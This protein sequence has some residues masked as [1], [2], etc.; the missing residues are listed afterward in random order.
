M[1]SPY[2]L[3]TFDERLIFSR[4]C[5]LSRINEPVYRIWFAASPTTITLSGAN[6]MRGFE[7]EPLSPDCCGYGDIAGNLANIPKVATGAPAHA[8]RLVP[9]CLLSPLL[10]TIKWHEFDV[11]RFRFSPFAHATHGSIRRLRSDG[12]HH[13]RKLR[14]CNRRADRNIASFGRPGLRVSRSRPQRHLHR[15]RRAS[16]SCDQRGHN[17]LLL[18]L[19][20]SGTA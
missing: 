7:N 3:S 15:K 12:L 20:G 4:P 9:M 2:L 19:R 13:H 17:G 1:T 16:G 14:S 18:D 11:R 6:I 8:G 5:E 10:Q